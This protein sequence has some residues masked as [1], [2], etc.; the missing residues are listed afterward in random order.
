MRGT[1]EIG[2]I[3]I[4]QPVFFPEAAWIEAP[5]FLIRR[6]FGKEY[7]RKSRPGQGAFKFMLT[8]IYQGKC[9]ITGGK[10]STGVRSCT[11]PASDDERYE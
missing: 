7:L 8:E 2:S 1:D 11:H 6:V 5:N 10:H 4:E 9:A 3:I